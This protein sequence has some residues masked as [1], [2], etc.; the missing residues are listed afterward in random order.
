M[1]H[2][3]VFV[4]AGRASGLDFVHFNGMSGE[5]YLPEVT[6]GGAALF[7]YDGD[8][9]LDV[10]L[11]QGNML[12]PE[13]K[14]GEATFASP[15]VLPL[16]DR[17]LRNDLTPT[18]SAAAT[19]HLVDVT[20]ASG[21]HAPGYGM[22]VATADYDGDGFVDLYVTNL[23]PN[24]LLR[25]R[26]DGTFADV[27]A[28]A[29]VDDTRWSVPATFFDLDG[30]QDLD[31]FV[32]NYVNFAYVRHRKCST[33]RGAPDYCGPLAYSP[34][35]DRLFRNRGDGTFEDISVPSGL[36]SAA[37]NALG[38]IAIDADDDGNMDIYVANDQMAN[39]LWINQGDAKFRNDAM[40]SGTAVNRDGLAEASMG[41]DAADF[42]GDLDEDLFL[43]HLGAETNTLYQNLGDGLFN[44]VTASV[45]LAQ[46]SLP[47]TGF[48]TRFLDFDN[49]GWLDLY[50][51]NGAV[52]TVE[53]QAREGDPYPLRQ[54]NQ[55]FRNLKGVRFEDVS[56]QAGQPLN[57]LEVSRGTAVGD[58]DS[59]GDADLLQVNSAGRPQLLLNR[60]G[61]RANWV[62]LAFVPAGAYDSSARLHLTSATTTQVRR[63]HTD[64]SYASASDPRVVIGVGV[65][66]KVH[67]VEVKTAGGRHL[68]WLEP[69]LNRYLV[70]PQHDGN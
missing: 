12:G 28:A 25:N 64:G 42:D 66:E 36:A 6:G 32:G 53:A 69:P 2:A 54:S 67:S 59:D 34:V 7:D 3:Q 19:P 70:L 40:L 48:G 5:L 16:S 55:L 15:A 14:R 27:T 63:V 52:R 50:A 13:G 68:K 35:S 26:G 23:G 45:G 49:D 24:Q 41:V 18:G 60:E 51:A 17:L 39:F 9:D 47:F 21:I 20:G 62:G 61:Q 8:G 1:T 44:D 57:A 65:A 43:T 31:L 38:A 10:Y 29:G 22:G 37:G 58:I 33:R 4:D 56:D 46:P 11:V 30:D